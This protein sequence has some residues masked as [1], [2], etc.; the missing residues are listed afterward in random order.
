[1]FIALN[2][3]L[4]KFAEIAA[5]RVSARTSAHTTVP[6]APDQ[7]VEVGIAHV[8]LDPPSDTPHRPVQNPLNPE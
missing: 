5:R 6:G 2:Y 4:S 8:K 3:L 7:A 1:M